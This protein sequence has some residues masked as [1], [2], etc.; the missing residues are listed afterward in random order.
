MGYEVTQGV[1]DAEIIL[2]LK[3]GQ[4]THAARR[5]TCDCGGGQWIVFSSKCG[6]WDLIEHRRDQLD[7]GFYGDQVRYYAAR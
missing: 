1:E 7:G 5:E 6:E 3:N 2:Y 4:P